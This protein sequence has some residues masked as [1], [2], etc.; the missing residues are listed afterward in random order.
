MSNRKVQINKQENLSINKNKELRDTAIMHPKEEIL[1]KLSSSEEETYRTFFRRQRDRILYTGGFRRLQDKTQVMEATEDGDHR[2][3]LTHTLEVEQIAVSIADALSLNSDVCSAIALGHDVGHTPFG[4]AAERVLNEKLKN[5]GGFKHALQS[6]RYLQ[7]KNIKLSRNILHGIM[8]HDTDMVDLGDEI[9]KN[10]QL[11]LEQSNS[12][13]LNPYQYQSLEGQVVYW[14]DKFA[15][16]THDLEDYRTNFY[17]ADDGDDNIVEIEKRLR[18][19]LNRE[20]DT[21]IKIETYSTRDLIRKITTNLIETSHSN[22]ENYAKDTEI[23]KG[24]KKKN[25]IDNLTINLDKE[26]RIAFTEARKLLASLYINNYHIQHSDAKAE[27]IIEKL[28][29][30]L[31]DKIGL[32]PPQWRITLRNEYYKTQLIELIGH[33]IL[34]KTEIYAPLWYDFKVYYDIDSLQN[35]EEKYIHNFSIWV[36]FNYINSSLKVNTD[37][38][39]QA[40]YNSIKNEESKLRKNILPNKEYDES[41]LS[42]VDTENGLNIEEKA[43]LIQKRIIA[44]YLSSMTDKHAIQLYNKLIGTF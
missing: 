5:I 25:Y 38:K 21:T 1:T 4:H 22:I 23:E 8:M 16:L 30:I 43:K 6:I 18:I 35:I 28:F 37:E 9:Y 36:Y 24:T 10:T 3:R 7:Y 27:R 42:K 19:L 14:A 33:D 40:I 31:S 29:H 41:I 32:L 17:K 44:D 2:T 20:G 15:Y 34:G 26:K 12:E 39:V 11:C 13:F